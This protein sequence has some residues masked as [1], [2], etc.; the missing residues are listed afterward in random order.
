MRRY[1]KTFIRKK[2]P[3]VTS[4]L[5][6]DHGIKQDEYVKILQLTERK[7]TYTEL[8]VFSAMWNEHC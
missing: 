5:I 6:S 7:L 4:K 3:K 1:S 2:E 8:G